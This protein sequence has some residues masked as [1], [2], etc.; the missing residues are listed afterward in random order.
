MSTRAAASVTVRV[1]ANVAAKVY[2]WVTVGPGPVVPSP[3]A[4]LNVYGDVPPTAV[5]ENVT[6]CPTAG[7]AG[8]N[9]KS[10]TRAPTTETTFV[11]VLSWDAES[12]TVSVTMKSP[13]ETYEWLAVWPEPVDPSPNA[14]LKLYGAVPPEAD[15]EN[16]T[17]W[18]IT[19]FAGVNVKSALTT[20]VTVM[21]FGTSTTRSALSVTVRVTVNVPA[22][23]YAWF[24][25]RPEIVVPSPKSHWYVYG[26]EPPDAVAT[27]ETIWPTTGLDG[28]NEKSAVSAEIT[29]TERDLV[30][31]WAGGPP[32]SVTVRITMN[33]PGDGNAWPT[34]CPVPVAPSPNAQL[35]PY[36]AVPPD[37]VATKETVWPTT[38]LDGENEKSAVSVAVT[39][40]DLDGAAA[41]AGDAESVT[42]SVTVK[43]PAKAYEWVGDWPDPLGVPSPQVQLYAYCDVPPEAVAEKLTESPAWGFAGAYV[44]SAAS[45]DVTTI[46]F[47]VVSVIGGTEESVTARDTV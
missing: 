25:V 3:N 6:V 29:V 10:A 38:G 8:E 45:G 11:T 5:P 2:A 27:K 47:E 20:S 15:A 24:L 35:K 26:V 28:E 34:L 32:E 19:G 14:Q 39:A 36:G 41:C 16:E 23:E 30:A 22:D 44:K 18:P 21:N 4:Q 13:A 9:V 37:A 7:L 1:T 43:V 33:V 12:D 42:V 31:V 46:G 17:D 40:T